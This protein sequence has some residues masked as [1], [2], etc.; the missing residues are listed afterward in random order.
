M[1]DEA[2]EPWLRHDEVIAANP[3]DGATREQADVAKLPPGQAPQAG[4]SQAV[5]L[6]AA[7]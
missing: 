6:R 3:G 1:D 4:L 2:C 5:R 7:V